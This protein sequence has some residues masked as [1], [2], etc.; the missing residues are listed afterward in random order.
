M[1]NV[2]VVYDNA[3]EE[4]IG[5]LTNMPAARQTVVNHLAKEVETDSPL[6]QCAGNDLT[7]EQVMEV[8]ASPEG[9]QYYHVFDMEIQ[10]FELSESPVR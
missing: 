6:W 8:L 4:I 1:G 2:Y 7:I 5:I 3:I 10:T 9:P